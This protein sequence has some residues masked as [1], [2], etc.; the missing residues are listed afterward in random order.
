MKQNFTDVWQVILDD[1]ARP[2]IGKIEFCEPNTTTL[3]EIYD[4]TENVTENPMYVN[5]RTTHQILLG[6]G[7][8]TVRYYRYIGNGNMESDNNESSWFNYKTEL[9]KGFDVSSSISSGSSVNTIAELKNLEANDGDLV[10]VLGYYDVNDCPSREYVWQANR[11]AQDDGGVYIKSNKT[12]TGVWVMKI[13]GSYIDVRWYGDLPDEI[14]NPSATQQK[15]NLGQRAAAAEQA[16]VQGKDL[17]FPRG[18][19]IFD[20]SNTVSTSKDIIMDNG[21]KFVVKSGTNGTKI[22]CHELHKCDKG[23][24]I[25][26]SDSQIGGYELVCDWIGSSWF[27]PS[28]TNAN[29]ARI[30]YFIETDS[31]RSVPMSFSNTKVDVRGKNSFNI[32][33]DNVEIV[34]SNHMLTKNITIQH[35]FINQN[36]F[37][38]DYD[39]SNLTVYNDCNV[40]LIDCIDANNYIMLKNRCLKYD[41]GDLGEQTISDAEIYPGGTLE[42]FYGSI[43]LKANGNYEFHNATVTIT[44]LSNP[45]R[46]LNCIDTWLTIS[47]D[48][49]VTGGFHLLRG[50]IFSDNDVQITSTCVIRNADINCKLKLYGLN[51]LEITDCKIWNILDIIGHDNYIITDN[52]F[53]ANSKLQYE[54]NAAIMYGTFSNNVIK[55]SSLGWF[56]SSNVPNTKVNCSFVNN[57]SDMTTMFITL[58]R[59]NLDSDESVH[60]YI[61]E[62]NTGKNVV[63][64]YPRVSIETVTRSAGTYVDGPGIYFNSG[65]YYGP[66][67]GTTTLDKTKYIGT[68]DMFTI[69]TSHVSRKASAILDATSYDSGSMLTGYIGFVSSEFNSFGT[70]MV[71]KAENIWKLTNGYQWRL[72]SFRSCPL[73]STGHLTDGKI[74]KIEIEFK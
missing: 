63:Q 8:Y 29:G 68:F 70:D 43:T 49:P 42:N 23:L 55:S 15:S 45:S 57:F 5:K 72:G 30:G 53:E 2:L 6:D 69:G 34:S 3:K 10:R 14:K 37:E 40:R 52:V 65:Y 24:F 21:V 64:R 41:Y 22:Q 67:V 56:V 7:D 18:Y 50:S 32:T 60:G 74:V 20:G 73:F 62:N 4:D 47:D 35:M 27:S 11:L 39:W 12:T 71:S 19:Y 46:V 36:W 26:N 17:Y 28:T 44:G 54:S 16:M 66:T 33:F 48:S 9:V 61:Y 31:T 25:S 59:T 1:N 51:T 58:D 38:Y 13:P